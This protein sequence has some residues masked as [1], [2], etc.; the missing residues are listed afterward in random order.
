M[1]KI[2]F[3]S[4]VERYLIDVSGTRTLSIHKLYLMCRDN[5]RIVDPLCLY[6][7]LNKKTDIFFKYFSDEKYDIFKSLT[8]DNF[9]D[10]RYSDYSFQKIYQSY[11]RKVNISQ[12]D[13]EIKTKIRKNIIDMM[14]EKKITNYR[15]YKDLEL[16]PGNVNDFLT[17][18]NSKKVS[19][20]LV[21]RIYNYCLL[22]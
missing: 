3:N 10:K 9:L 19:L 5:C 20:S 2:T 6:C 12:Y 13:N 4:F 22:F 14:K 15:I 16:N 18:N 8:K 21:K 1:R 7:V 11:L 17:N